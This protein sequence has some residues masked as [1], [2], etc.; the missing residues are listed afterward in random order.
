M[1]MNKILINVNIDNTLQVKITP[2]GRKIDRR[3]FVQRP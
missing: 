1:E 2:P 3:V